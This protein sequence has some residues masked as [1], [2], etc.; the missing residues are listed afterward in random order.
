M[1][2]VTDTETDQNK[3]SI[4][5]YMYFYRSKFPEINI[6]PKQYILYNNIDKFLMTCKCD[7]GLSGEQGGKEL[8]AFVNELKAR[9]RGA[10]NE[11]ERLC[12]LM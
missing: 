11:E 3:S 2:P 9:E 6:I 4:R 5:D 10:N 7:L 1:L 12:L 8:H